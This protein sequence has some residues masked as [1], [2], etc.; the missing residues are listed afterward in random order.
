MRII[1]DDEN[2]DFI[3]DTALEHIG[4][5]MK[6]LESIFVAFRSTFTAVTEFKHIYPLLRGLQRCRKLS[7]LTVS[8]DDGYGA[9]K[10]WLFMNHFAA[11]IPMIKR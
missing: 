3:Q 11:T 8:F 4:P 5:K 9:E 6:N 7:E 2:F 1:L 10:L